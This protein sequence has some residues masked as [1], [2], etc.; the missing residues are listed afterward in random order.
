MSPEE[1]PPAPEQTGGPGPERPGP[2][3]SDRH[4]V[5]PSALGIARLLRL[6]RTHGPRL[7]G[8]KIRDG[9]EIPRFGLMVGI[10]L[11]FL[12]FLSLLVLFFLPGVAR[13]AESHGI[14]FDKPTKD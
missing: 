6:R 10:L 9:L 12:I 3:P 8:Q 7:P 1:R 5:S 2:I 11:T 4:L 14:N 13:G